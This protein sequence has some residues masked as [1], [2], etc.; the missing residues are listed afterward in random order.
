VIRCMGGAAAIKQMFL[1]C[2]GWSGLACGL[3]ATAVCLWF[4][5]EAFQGIAS[6]VLTGI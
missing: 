1:G 6:G 5:E 2:R 3:A 4:F